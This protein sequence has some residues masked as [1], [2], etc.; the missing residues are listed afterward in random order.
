MNKK[1]PTF[2]PLLAFLC[3]VLSA[4]LAFSQEVLNVTQL[5]NFGKGEGESKAVFAA[6]SLVFYGLGSKVQ[7]ASFSVPSAPVRIASV[8]LSE[9]VEDLVRTSIG[10]NQYLV[11]TGG[12]KMWL[13]NV[14]NPTTPSL[15]STVEVGT[16][17]ICEGVATSGTYAYVAAGGAGLK[18]YSIATPA[19]P[20]LAASIDSL[21]YCESVV[22]SSPYAYIAAAGRSHIVNIST[23]TAPVYTGRIAGYGGYHQYLNVR[24]GYAYVC[25]FDAG[26]QVINVTNPANPVNVMEVPTGHRTARIVFDGNYGYVANG[27]SGMRII[28]VVNPAAPTYVSRIGTVGRAASVY[29]GAITIGGNPTGHI[30]VSNRTTVS[31]LSAI[32]VS[33]PATPT[34]SGFLGSQ[35]AASGSAFSAFYDNN[36]VYVAYG[37]AGLRILDVS[38][39]S[40]PTLLG[41]LDT[42]GEARN[43]VVRSGYAYVADMDSGVRVIN[44]T[45]PAAPVS[46]R[47][48]ATSRARGIAINGNYVYVATRDSG[49]VVLNITNPA[50]PTWLTNVRGIDVENVA[51][52]GNVV[53]TSLFNLIRFYNVTNPAA[54]VAGGQTGT[55]VSGNEG[56]AI[57]G[58][59]AYAPDGDSLRV[60]NI[61]NI[62]TPVQVGKVWTRGYGYAAA[63]SGNYVYVPADDRG[64]RVVNITNPAAPVLAG[65]YDGVPIARGVAV[66]GG[67]AYVAERI[68]GLT[69]YRNDLVVSVEETGTSPSSFALH[70]NYPN[71]FNPT[72]EIRFQIAE[73]RGQRSEVSRV[74]MKV[75]DVLGR[76]VATLVNEPMAAGI[77]K[78]TWDASDFPTGVYFY[79][80]SAGS[81]TET[82]KMILAK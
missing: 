31:G 64:L 53:A 80:L 48:I 12:S 2:H 15:T 7:I 82:R 20:T 76:E 42:P 34:T 81:I 22:I 75:Y 45:N 43:V 59:F 69:V 71:P 38:T 57:A 60:Y 25:N 3:V 79:K 30:Y 17:A 74:T 29:Y 6:G 10:G 49:L 35:N 19:S 63:I 23:P 9:V 44:A 41:V 52:A 61:S 27:D 46:I 70:Q 40:N 14:Q 39:P 62:A 78:A 8:T 73:V 72:T 36:K 54:P 50:N 58:N 68:D 51:A 24:S 26:L 65:F 21:A 1:I 33:I 5:G 28:N 47:G 13:I 16:G 55:L 18:I 66:D 11:V 67:F 4:Q 32:N 37:S 77:H 56:L